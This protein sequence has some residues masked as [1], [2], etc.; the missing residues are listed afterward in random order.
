MQIN[1]YIPVNDAQAQFI[2]MIGAIHNN[3]STVAITK[4]GVPETIM[5]SM[6]QWESIQETMDILAD[7]SALEQ[8]RAS[9]REE[10]EGRS[11]VDLEDIL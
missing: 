4:N 5:M 11:F 8:L 1:S 6:E 9:I 7:K 3:N 2:D 10:Q